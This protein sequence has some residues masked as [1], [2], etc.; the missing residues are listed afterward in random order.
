[1]ANIDK[2]IVLLV[3]DDEVDILSTQR[4]FISAEISYDLEIVNNG[5]EALSYLRN[6]KNKRPTL[7]LLDLNMPRMNGIELLKIIKNDTV[8]KK[9]PI[10]VLT[11][12]KMDQDRIES[13][14]FSVAG[15]IVKPVSFDKLVQSFKIINDYWNLMELPP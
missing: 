8:L 12:S 9:I 6:S 3:E 10:I 4:A 13:Y 11:S 5:E 2:N 7:I 14:E 1:M 15:Y